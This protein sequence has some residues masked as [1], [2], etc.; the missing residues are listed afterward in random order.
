[1]FNHLCKLWS[2]IDFSVLTSIVTAFAA[3]IALG[4][5][6]RQIKLSNRQHLFDKRIENYLIATGLIQLYRKSCNSINN[7]DGPRFA[8]DREFMYLTN[9]SY[10]QGITP[11]IIN[12]LE[13]QSHKELLIKLENLKEVATKI[14]FL[15]SDDVSILLAD[16]VLCYKELLF[17]MYR[18]RLIEKRIQEENE[19]HELIYE[20][21]LEKFDEKKYR[22][23]VQQALDNLKQADSMLK[24]KSVEEQIEKAIKLC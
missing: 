7:I 10:L 8:I 11:A 1:M 18:Y 4:L 13:E 2:S 17:E 24:K 21:L 9:N 22:D 20:Q 23:E 5:T 16:F 6:N 19:K 12:P 3:I 15:F 14:K